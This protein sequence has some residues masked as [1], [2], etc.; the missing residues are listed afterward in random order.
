MLPRAGSVWVSYLGDLSD[1]CSFYD[2]RYEPVFGP[3][4]TA[5]DVASTN[6]SNKSIVG[7]S[8]IFWIEEG[9]SISVYYVLGTAF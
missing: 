5:D 3:V 7:F 6:T 8:K 2:I 4:S 9:V 1:I